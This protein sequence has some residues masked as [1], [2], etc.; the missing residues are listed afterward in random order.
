MLGE[1]KEPPREATPPPPVE[2]LPGYLEEPVTV[3]QI[4][5]L[6]YGSGAHRDAGGVLGIGLPKLSVEQG[7]LLQRAKKYAMEV[8]IKLVLMKQT[9][10]H[11]QQ[12]TKYLQRQQAVSIMS[13]IYVGCI[14]YDTKEDSI[15]TAFLPFGPIRSITMSW[16]A[17]TGKHKGFAFVEFEQPEAAQLALD[18][19]N[20]ILVCG[21]NIKV[22]R[23]SQMPQAQACIDEIMT[24]AKSYNR[25]YLAS[26]HRDLTEEDI[27]SVFSAFGTIKDC[28]MANMGTPGQHKGYGYIEYET[29]QSTDE[30]ISAMNMFDLGGM[31]LRVGRA[32]TPP[33]TR[34]LA[35][36]GGVP[37]ALPSSAAVAAAA[38]T[39]QIQAMD[40]VASNM[41]L[42]SARLGSSA[43][44][45]NLPTAT[46]GQMSL[47]MVNPQIAAMNTYPGSSQLRKCGLP[48]DA[49][50]RPIKA[51][52]QLTGGM[53]PVAP[54]SVRVTVSRDRSR[55]PRRSRGRSRSRSRGRRSRSRDRGSRRR[56]RSRGRRSRSRSPGISTRSSE[57]TGAELRDMRNRREMKKVAEAAAAIAAQVDDDKE[58]KKENYGEGEPLS[59][60]EKMKKEE[61]LEKEGLEPATLQ[62]EEEGKGVSKSGRQLVME[63][64]M[65]AAAGK[66][67]SRV[68]LLTNMVGPEDVDEDLQEDVE[69]ECN[70][71]GKVD[72]IVIYQEKQDESEDAEVLV[73]IFVEFKE[74]ISAKKAKNGLDGRFFA[75]KTISAIIYDQV[76]FDQ[77]DYSY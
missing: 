9:M 43:P 49:E 19:M 65:V 25:L 15:K 77:Q 75:G 38:V 26:I 40:A 46:M 32:I 21:R 76:L 3:T 8:S 56:S 36:S 10:A 50:G 62:Q 52:S 23:P 44:S 1:Q 37:S 34:N 67:E 20:G 73:K 66:M 41:G 24:E 45:L 70:K 13:R 48:R 2:P 30:A 35:L 68:I 59:D 7:A 63:K 12:Q 27:R 6:V 16:D 54:P 47:S 17:M 61:E 14:N 5:K 4:D 31:L 22:G 71:Y 29:R 60:V 33:D 74:S 69:Q 53:T 42:D 58:V 18:Q 57:M 51:M 28:D 55:S 11:Q 64:L 72:H 39:A